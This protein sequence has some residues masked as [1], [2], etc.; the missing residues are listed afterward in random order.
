VRLLVDANRFT[1]FARGNEDVV[2]RFTAA[3]E[4]WISLVVLGELRAGFVYGSK[5][6]NNEQVLQQFLEGATVGVLYL[7]E[8]TTK[9]YATVYGALRG[10]GTPIPTND[11]WIAA[12]SI[13]HD[14]TLDTRDQHFRHVPGLKLVGATS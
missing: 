7:D 11:M 13:Q 3:E 12:L 14:L 1:D 8:E 6:R 2:A 10:Q 4:L 5:R 9:H